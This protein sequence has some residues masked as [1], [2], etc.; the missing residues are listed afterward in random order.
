VRWPCTVPND[1]AVTVAN[2]SGLSETVAGTVLPPETPARINWNMSPAY[3]REQHGH[4]DARRF[5]QRT[6]VTPSGSWL[7][8]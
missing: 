4:S 8:E 6:C 5:P 1:G 3:S 7:L 2:T